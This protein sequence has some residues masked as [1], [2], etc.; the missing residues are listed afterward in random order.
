MQSDLVGIFSSLT[1]IRKQ[2]QHLLENEGKRQ[3]RHFAAPL[4][5]YENVVDYY[6]ALAWSAGFYSYAYGGVVQPDTYQWHVAQRAPMQFK[7]D[8]SYTRAMFYA[9]MEFSYTLDQ[10]VRD[11][12]ELYGLLDSLGVNFNPA[13]I[14]NAIPF[15]F[16]IDWVAGVS[17]WLDN[18]KIRLIEPRTSISNYCWAIN[19]VRN[20]KTFLSQGTYSSTCPASSSQMADVV[21]NLYYRFND[22]PDFS[23]SLTRSGLSSRE[24]ILGGALAAAMATR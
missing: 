16:V 11:N 21:E 1:N 19:V 7:R 4:T 2:V 20:T 15:S 24:F 5:G 6:H 9:S 14:W 22:A 13:I 18:Y 17:R 10:Y 8:Y 23:G 3:V 12:A